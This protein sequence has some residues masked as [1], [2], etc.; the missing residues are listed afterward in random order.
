LG[1]AHPILTRLHRDPEG[2][3]RLYEQRLMTRQQCSD[4]AEEASPF[5]SPTVVVGVRAGVATLRGI[6]CAALLWLRGVG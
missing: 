4:G 3:E 1:D 6:H 2:R 5:T